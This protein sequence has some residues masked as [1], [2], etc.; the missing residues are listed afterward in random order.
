MFILTCYNQFSSRAKD[1]VV[2]SSPQWKSVIQKPVCCWMCQLRWTSP[3][4]EAVSYFSSMM[5]FSNVHINMTVSS[6]LSFLDTLAE[7]LRGSLV[8]TF[9]FLRGWILLTLLTFYLAPS[10]AHIF[11]LSITLIYDVCASNDRTLGDTASVCYTVV[12][13]LS[14]GERVVILLLLKSVQHM[15]AELLFTETNTQLLKLLFRTKT[16]NT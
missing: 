3:N 4:C 6:F 9:M 2:I 10:S 13:F 5:C 15:R 1:Q 11:K 7:C 14:E 8:Q 12:L 16:G